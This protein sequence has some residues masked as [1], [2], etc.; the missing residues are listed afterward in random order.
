MS[1]VTV[2]M[3][4]FLGEYE[5]CAGDRENKFVRAVHSFLDNTYSNK[6]LV[7]VGDCCEIT[8]RLVK[9]H[10]REHLSS[11]DIK[12]IN[13]KKKQKLF[14][15]KVRSTGL[16]IAT[17]NI[18]MY[19]DTDDMFGDK[20]IKSVANQMNVQKLDWCYYSDYLNT[21]EGL[22]KK[23]VTLEHGSIGTSSIAHLNRA[24][25]SWNKCNGYG[26]DW[27]FVQRLIKW[28]SNYAK[29][30]GATYII[31]HLPNHLDR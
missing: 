9:E 27:K 20:H 8:E 12:F 3:A 31:C 5:G 18:I 30:Y 1:K 28:S 16:E 15:G 23:E 13:L 6:E 4:S 2:V 7:I 11:G 26:H 19:L 17:G 21:E 25:I 24:D 10:F 29:I 14:S 22:V